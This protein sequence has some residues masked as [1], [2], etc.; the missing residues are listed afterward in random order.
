MTNEGQK[1]KDRV[2]TLSGLHPTRVGIACIYITCNFFFLIYAVII[3]VVRA[4]GLSDFSNNLASDLGPLLSLFGDAVTRQYLSESTTFI[5]YFIFAMA[6]IG[7]ISTITAV[8]RVCGSSS[9][10]AFI[11]RAQEGQGTTE[12]ELC[13]STSDDVCE[14]FN[15][16]GITRVLGRPDIIELVYISDGD[17][18]NKNQQKEQQRAQPRLQLFTSYLKYLEDGSNEPWQRIMSSGSGNAVFNKIG[19]SNRGKSLDLAP[20][21]NLSLNVGIRRQPDWVFYVIALIGF[22]LQ[23]GILVFAGTAVWLLEW[24]LQKP[25]SEASRNYAPGIVI[26]GT[27]ALCIGVWSCTALIGQTTDEQYYRRSPESSDVLYWIQPGPQV[28]GDQSFGSF[29]YSDAKSKDRLMM[30]TSSTKDF[31]RNF[32]AITYIA[33]SLVLVGYIAQFIGLRGLNA[34]ISM[35]QLGITMI[36]SILRGILRMKRLD[37]NNNRLDMWQDL[38][39]GDELD[40]LVFDIAEQEL[41]KKLKTNVQNTSVEKDEWQTSGKKFVWYITGQHEKAIRLEHVAAKGSEPGALD[42]SRTNGDSNNTEWLVGYNNDLIQ[43]RSRLSNLTGHF[44]ESMDEKSYLSWKDDRVRVRTKAKRLSTV[45]S[46]AAT[47][48]TIRL[49]PP[50]GP[51][52]ILGLWLWSVARREYDTYRHKKDSGDISRIPNKVLN[53]KIFRVV[54]ACHGKHEWDDSFDSDMSFWLGSGDLNY[55]YSLADH[56]VISGDNSLRS[57]QDT[58]QTTK[59]DNEAIIYQRVG[60]ISNNCSAGFQ[61]FCGWNL[62]YD[63]LNI[64]TSEE[65]SN[66]ASE[67]VRV[68]VKGFLVKDT[69]HSLLDICAQELFVALLHSMEALEFRK[70]DEI[71]VRESGGNIHLEIPVISA[72]AKSFTDNGLGTHSDAISCLIPSLRSQIPPYQEKYRQDEE[73]NSAEV[74]LSWACQYYHNYFIVAL[75]ELGELYRR[76][77]TQGHHSVRQEFSFGAA[78]YIVALYITRWMDE[79]HYAVVD[80]SRADALFSLCFA[81]KS[82]SHKLSKSLLPAARNGWDEILHALLEMTPSPNHHD[83]DG[84]TL[85]SYCAELS[86]RQSLRR[87]MDM[88]ADLDLA[89]KDEMTPLAYAAMNGREDVGSGDSSER[90]PLWLA[91]DQDHFGIMSELLDKGADI[92]AENIK[93]EGLLD[94]ALARGKS[95]TVKSLIKHGLHINLAI[96]RESTKVYVHPITWAVWRGYAALVRLLLEEDETSKKDYYEAKEARDLLLRK[97][98]LQPLRNHSDGFFSILDMDPCPPAPTGDNQSIQFD[99][100]YSETP[101]LVVGISGF[102]LEKRSMIDMSLEICDVSETGFNAMR[103][104]HSEERG[105]V[106]SVDVTWIEIDAEDRE[107]QDRRSII[108]AIY[109]SA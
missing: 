9:L 28:I 22:I 30:W 5:D 108:A 10:R 7:I 12:A 53:S 31:D 72:L 52:P 29:A 17:Q 83:H 1:F 21:P 99:P 80:C 45:V 91:A 82:I 27:I 89:D 40:W 90:N 11:G 20:K 84:R 78:N 44:D 87:L 43:N 25:N 74:V 109:Q 8:I 57:G 77:L 60:E 76:S 46:Q 98:T 38:V 96:H 88:N 3:V 32:E 23:V 19:H 51:D 81:G 101:R 56:W 6:P 18:T 75:R 73:W 100:P 35:A 67:K 86:L 50:T 42:T 59:E 102:I 39:T 63:E 104:R 4:D 2:M 107:F 34:W 85:V 55:K 92:N 95:G 61:R 54:S 71:S 64:A 69:E 41:I 94:F 16:G 103:R 36:M 70:L 106:G 24:N 68:N 105:P 14:L 62:I 65:E 37:R 58:G 79:F 97:V 15:K 13:T 48:V 26:A 47:I 49:K 33:V 66:N 93:G